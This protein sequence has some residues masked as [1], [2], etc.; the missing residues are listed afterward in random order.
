MIL[1]GGGIISGALLACPILVPALEWLPLSPR[2]SGFGQECL[3]FSASWYDMIALVANNP[4][5]DL[6]LPNAR[7][8]PLVSDLHGSVPYVTSDFLGAGV[9]T[10]AIWGLCDKTWKY[11]RHLLFSFLASILLALG[12]NT[13][14]DP[15][16]VSVIPA[17]SVIR[18]PVKLM[19][20]PIFCLCI[21]AARGAGMV[22]KRSVPGVA[23]FVTLFVWIVPIV[24]ACDI[25]FFLRSILLNQPSLA[26]AAFPD[27]F[28]ALAVAAVPALLLVFCSSR[29]FPEKLA[30]TRQGMALLLVAVPLLLAGCES[31]RFST[32]GRFF[33]RPSELAGAIREAAGHSQARVVALYQ[34]HAIEPDTFVATANMDGAKKDLTLDKVALYHQYLR[35]VLHPNTNIDGQIASSF[36]YEAAEMNLYRRYFVSILSLFHHGEVQSAGLAGKAADAYQSKSLSDA[37]ILLGR[38]CKIT[39]TGLVL[40]QPHSPQPDYR[41]LGPPGFGLITELPNLNQRLYRPTADVRRSYLVYDWAPCSDDRAM[42][43]LLDPHADAFDPYARALTDP[44]ASIA[45]MASAASAHQHAQVE[46]TDIDGEHV[47]IKV[48]TDAPS[49]LILTDQYY[50]GWKATIDGSETPVIKA[51][52]FN[53]AVRL[54]AGRHTV[55]FS[56]QPDSLRLGILAAIV[57]AGLLIVLVI[58]IHQRGQR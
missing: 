31:A 28:G 7:F 44:S 39:G 8:L 10:L 32:D 54:S 48:T 56:Y 2:S 40:T 42:T 46:V 18:Y 9:I 11:R 13:P 5:G 19:I 55:N 17:L 41:E 1:Q 25:H 3:R 53:R 58:V 12:K 33:I 30:K 6:F 57:G 38:F 27:I 50:P 4:L 26:L 21:M 52:I 29:F 49:L 37:A 22:E 51:N 47:S 34:G 23:L 45:G 16:L 36:G 24:M 35:Q 14:L 15:L 20:F 43:I